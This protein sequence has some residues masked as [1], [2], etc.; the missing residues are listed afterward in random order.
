MIDRNPMEKVE[1]PK[2]RKD[3]EQRN[4]VESYTADELRHILSC[5]DNE[6]LK[7]QAL[8]RL[9]IDTGMRRGEAC[10]LQWKNVNF[11]DCTVPV[12]QTL[13][14][15]K[16][17]SVYLGAPKNGKQRTIDVDEDVMALLRDLRVQQ[18]DH[19]ISAFVFTQEGS[20]AP[21]HPQSPA[22]YLQNFS[23]RYGI[24]HLHP[25]KL[26]HSFASVAITNGADIASVSEKLGHA[27]KSTTL[28][29]Y[30]HADQESMK[31]ASNI[32]REALRK[33]A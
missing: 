2:Q 20:N 18:A 15:T 25:H 31:R 24:D 11:A 16:D 13:N 9:I 32:F 27:D 5:L 30:T 17:K 7:W 28:R 14:Y 3:S 29:K 22:R 8:M 4:E 6:P 33:Q 1:R 19:A 10:G 23:K 12:A 26:R 21:M